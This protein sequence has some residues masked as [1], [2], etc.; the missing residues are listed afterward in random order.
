MNL[1]VRTRL[2]LAAPTAEQRATVGRLTEDPASWAPL[3]VDRLEQ[4]REDRAD[5]LHGQLA[6][7]AGQL[8]V[9]DS[10]FAPADFA[11]SLHGPA[12]CQTARTAGFA[13]PLV[14]VDCTFS[15]QPETR[16]TMHRVEVADSL[17]RQ[18]SSPQLARAV[19]REWAVEDRCYALGRVAEHVEQLATCGLRDSAVN[20][21][22]GT[23]SASAVRKLLAE[24][25]PV[26]SPEQQ[27]RA[28][29]TTVQLLQAFEGDVGRFLDPDPEVSGKERAALLERMCRLLHSAGAD[30]R[31]QAAKARY[32]HATEQLEAAHNSLVVAAG[33]EGDTA[34]L[35]GQWALGHFVARPDGMEANDFVNARVTVVGAADGTRAAD[36]T[37]ADPE[38]DVYADGSAGEGGACGTSFAA[39]RVASRL[40]LL[41]AEAPGS[42]SEA[43]EQKLLALCRQP[44]ALQRPLVVFESEDPPALGRGLSAERTAAPGAAQAPGVS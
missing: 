15:L 11:G 42:S 29:R 23:N 7:R 6:G 41:H 4:L 38:L 31:W 5:W 22:L 8:V 3:H 26:G 33:N 39:P 34:E 16:E 9:L 17:W 10:F 14:A 28:G 30:E 25:M 20:L 44:G 36:Y 21:S 27:A 32:D 13:G 40:A 35:L 19:L 2:P 1:V 18:Q 12:V 43:V 37:S 24:T